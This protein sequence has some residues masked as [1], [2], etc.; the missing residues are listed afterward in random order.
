MPGPLQVDYMRTLKETTIVGLLLIISLI[1]LTPKLI[2]ADQAPSQAGMVV[3]SAS[4]TAT[5]INHGL[6]GSAILNLTGTGSKDMNQDLL[7]QN[8]TGSLNIGSTNLTVSDGHGS[9]NSYEE[10]TIFANTSLAGNELFLQGM[11][12]GNSVAFVSPQSHLSV[13]SLLTL[14]GSISVN[15]VEIN[16]ASLSTIRNSTGTEAKV[17]SSVSARQI[18]NAS[19]LQGNVTV[20]T[21]S[22]AYS[23]T[24]T[25][26]SNRTTSQ[27]FAVTVSNTAT[28]S[29]ITNETATLKAPSPQN[30]AVTVTQFNN[31]TISVTHTVA[32][33]T[34]TYTTTTTVASMTI[35]QAN[36]TR[37]TSN[38]AITTTT[39]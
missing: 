18:S 29:A 19:T 39:P 10:I 28:A 9:V 20:Q 14:S 35:T 31:Q 36:T 30:V 37:T 6:S 5:S 33:V 12:Q 32:N 4:G 3:I 21:V 23:T 15:G 1:S 13:L 27:A 34:I 38:S 7:I 8:I 24:S 16:S 2:L 26:V 25:S 17:T 22:V 11:I